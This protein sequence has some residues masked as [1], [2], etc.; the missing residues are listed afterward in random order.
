MSFAL[1]SFL[2]GESPD[3]HARATLAQPAPKRLNELCHV[4]EST[5]LLVLE[6]HFSQA[7]TDAAN[8]VVDRWV[9]NFKNQHGYVP[10]NFPFMELDPMFM[11]IMADPLVVALGERLCG[12]DGFRLD[13]AFGV[14]ARPRCRPAMDRSSSRTAIPA[15]CTVAR[16][17]DRARSFASTVSGRMMLGQLNIGVVLTDQSPEEW[18]LCFVPGSH[19]HS[20]SL[21][22]NDVLHEIYGGRFDH[23]SIVVPK[24]QIGDLV[25]FTE[26]LYHG[27]TPWSSGGR[28]RRTLYYKYAPGFVAWRD[29]SFLARYE[30]LARTDLQ[31]RLLRP[32]FVAQYEDE[33]ALSD[34]T[35]RSR[36]RGDRTAFEVLKEHSAH[37]MVTLGKIQRRL[38]R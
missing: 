34:H 37:P 23:P 29:P 22:G 7:Q 2:P 20:S 16:A 27:T 19:R 25:V 36:T 6:R 31:R 10:F 5:G 9:A 14:Q 33:P 12:R 35:I 30:P 1:S 17:P 15:T 4:F 21:Q 28:P 3:A 26:T 13:H 11:D 8:N 38:A 18:G 24:L 32:P